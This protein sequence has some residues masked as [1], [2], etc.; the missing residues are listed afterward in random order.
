VAMTCSTCRIHWFACS[1]CPLESYNSPLS[2]QI[3]NKRKLR[4]VHEKRLKHRELVAQW[5]MRRHN[6]NYEEQT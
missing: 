5:T 1:L 6:S 3:L 4:D 2:A